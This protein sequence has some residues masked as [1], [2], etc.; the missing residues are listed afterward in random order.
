[1]AA[2]C[3]I[4]YENDE[5]EVRLFQLSGCEHTICHVC[6]KT[7]LLQSEREMIDT[8][9]CP[10]C[11]MVF[12]IGLAEDVLGRP[13]EAAKAIKEEAREAP[14]KDLL[15]WLEA[16]GCQ[17]CDNCGAYIERED[18]CDAVMC[19]CGYRFCWECMVSAEDGCDCQHEDYYD[20][21]RGFDTS[22]EV[23]VA[24]SDEIRNLKVFLKARV[25]D[26]SEN[27][28]G[29]G[30]AVEEENEYIEEAEGISESTIFDYEEIEKSDAQ[31]CLNLQSVQHRSSL[32]TVNGSSHLRREGGN[33][34]VQFQT[35]VLGPMIDNNLVFTARN[36]SLIRCQ[37]C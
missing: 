19:L 17:Q 9:A 30:E 8:P 27:E 15:A 22:E 11:K 2:A 5:K 35:M 29:D 14:D 25:M 7:W 32:E 16:N 3:T 23:P 37:S 20:N 6:M 1:M 21:V 10:T 26:D 18:G 28:E 12:E 13:Y 34:D 31:D 24:T 4:C 36:Q 33:S